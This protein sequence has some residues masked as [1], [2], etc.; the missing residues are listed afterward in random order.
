MANMLV[1]AMR[2][3]VVT[4]AQGS[5]SERASR[6]RSRSMSIVDLGKCIVKSLQS[7]EG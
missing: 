6:A 3:M 2:S 7:R 4:V 5:Y 1:V